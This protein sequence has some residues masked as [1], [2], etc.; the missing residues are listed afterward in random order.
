MPFRLILDEMISPNISS[1]LWA[2][3]IDNYAIRDRGLLHAS[4]YQVWARAKLDARTLVTINEVHFRRLAETELSH[5]GII[6]IPDGGTRRQQLSYILSAT[7][8]AQSTQTT[9]DNL[10]VKVADDHSVTIETACAG[11]GSKP[12]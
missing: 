2:A 1:G 10:L 11:V 7:A 6:V 3:G 9:L 12:I 4:D 8:Y 5:C